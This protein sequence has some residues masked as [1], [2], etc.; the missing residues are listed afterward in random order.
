MAK[1]YVI[2]NSTEVSS[3]NFSQVQE[4]STDTLRWNIDQTKTFVK[5]E[6][7]TPSFLT[8]KTQYTNDQMLAMLDDVN[9]E[10]YIEDTTSN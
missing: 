4:T 6:G 3:I 9:G 2:L 7:D 8:G 10:W 5:F 1:K